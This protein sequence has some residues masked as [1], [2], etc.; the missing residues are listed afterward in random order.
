MNPTAQQKLAD[1]IVANLIGA[2][3][4]HPHDRERAADLVLGELSIANLRHE[5]KEEYAINTHHTYV[6]Q[7]GEI[8]RR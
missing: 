8:E 2:K 3:I 4:I 1:M 6:P 7:D 5:P